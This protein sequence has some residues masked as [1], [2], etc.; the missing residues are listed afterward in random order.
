MKSNKC[1]S[2]GNLTNPDARF[3]PQCGASLKE[4]PDFHTNKSIGQGSS[5]PARYLIIGSFVVII[6]I[7]I[8]LLVQFITLEE[9]NVI[10]RQPAV[11]KPVDYSDREIQMTDIDFRVEDG[12]VIFS[13]ADVIEHRIVYIDYQGPTSPIPVMAYISPNGKLVTAISINEPC[14][15]TRFKIVGN[16]IKAEKCR[17]IWDMSSM[18]A[19]ICCTNNYPDPI[20]SYVNGG[21][22]RIPERTIL[23]WNRRL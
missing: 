12:Y 14:N 19:H 7:L 3:C 13:V 22:V 5:S 10:A 1:P 2:C 20:P 4:Q 15:E 18:E 9:H 11:S 6:A 8:V 16:D 21:E 23:S 17:A